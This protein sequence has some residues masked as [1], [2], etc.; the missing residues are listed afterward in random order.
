MMVISE[1]AESMVNGQSEKEV[2]YKR[3]YW[4]QS[5]DCFYVYQSSVPDSV[6]PEE[7]DDSRYDVSRFD[8]V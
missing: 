2:I 6:Y 7:I 3:V 1:E 8:L 5:D 4:R